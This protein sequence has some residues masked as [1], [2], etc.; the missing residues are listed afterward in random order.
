M[1]KAV[2][3]TKQKEIKAKN[4]IT[5]A[6]QNKSKEYKQ[7]RI[8]CKVMDLGQS[9]DFEESSLKDKIEEPKEEAKIFKHDYVTLINREFGEN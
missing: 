7:S 3:S 2:I 6:D 8:T 9:K 1:L 5:K 4:K